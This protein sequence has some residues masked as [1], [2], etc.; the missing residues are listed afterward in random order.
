MKTFWNWFN[1][2]ALFFFIIGWIGAVE[3]NDAFMAS[4]WV[5]LA[6][7]NLYFYWRHTA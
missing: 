6:A 2:G 1:K 7:A 3:M 5:M 4:I